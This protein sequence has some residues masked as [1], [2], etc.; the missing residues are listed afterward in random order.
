[1]VCKRCGQCCIKVGSTFWTHA[2]GSGYPELQKW[3]NDAVLKGDDGMPCEMLVIEDGMAECY[4]ETCFGKEA[5]PEV[6]RD[7]PEEGLCFFE[8]EEKPD[9]EIVVRLKR[10]IKRLKREVESKE[11]EMVT[12][13]EEIT[14][15]RRL[16]YSCGDMIAKGLYEKML[17]IVD[18][19]D[20]RCLLA[21]KRKEPT[22]TTGA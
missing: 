20:S 10:R 9:T 21:T 14:K 3:I 6:C 5:K 2:D 7:Y 17:A 22:S 19:Y 16:I 4:I 18:E 13:G 1:M 12:R 8:Q 15:L 11:V